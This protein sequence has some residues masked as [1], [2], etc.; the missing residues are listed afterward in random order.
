MTNRHREIILPEGEAEKEI[1]RKSRR[2]F[3]LS[4]LAAVG[5]IGAY[6]AVRMSRLD[7]NVPWPQ[8]RVLDL[9]GKLWHSYLDHSHTMPTFPESEIGFLKANGDHGLDEEDDQGNPPEWEGFQLEMP[10]VNNMMLQL[11][12][13][14]SLPRQQMVTKFCCIEGWSVVQK[15]T[16]ARFSDFAKKFLPPGTSPTDYVYMATDG[17]DYFVGLDMKSALHP[18]T[19]LAWEQNDKPLTY[20]HGAPLRLVIP[21]KYGIKNIKR[22]G[23]MRFTNQKPRDFWHEQGYDWFA[24]L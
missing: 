22:I 4:G 15:W 18:Q 17:E 19:L 2:G 7:N 5:A 23:L 21:V 6:E 10:G 24:G 1:G 11:A 16:G 12:D 8:R 13:V 3:L 14:Q 9:N 20:E